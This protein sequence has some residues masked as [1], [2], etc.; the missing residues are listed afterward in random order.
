M[1]FFFFLM[2]RRPPRSTLFPYTTLF[3]SPGRRRLGAPGGG[4]R[5]EALEGCAGGAQVLLVPDRMRVGERLAPIGEGKSGIEAL[6]LAESLRRVPVLEAVQQQHTADELRLSHRGS[7]RGE[8]DRPEAGRLG[9]QR[10]A[11]GEE[12]PRR[13]HEPPDRASHAAKSTRKTVST[14]V[15]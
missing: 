1:M 9:R 10:R 3:R 11:S 8:I 6:R 2:I 12:R 15:R 7:R 5:A 13:P 4:R 14:R